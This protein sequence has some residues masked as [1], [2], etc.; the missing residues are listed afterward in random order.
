MKDFIH[1]NGFFQN[2]TTHWIRSFIVA[3]LFALLA[4]TLHAVGMLPGGGT[5]YSFP[6]PLDSWS[7]NDTTNWTS[8]LGYA[9]ASFTNITALQFGNVTSL[10][11]NTNI[12]AW[13]Q[14]NVAENDGTT[15]LTVDQGSVAFWFAPAWAG[16]NEGGSGPGQWGRLIEV[17][18]YTSDASFGWWSLYE[19]DVGANLYFTVQ[20][21]DGSTTTY[22]TAPIAWTTNYWHFIALT[23][24]ATNTALY[25]DGVLATNGTGITAWPGTNVLAGGFYIGS[26]S[27]GVIQAQGAF[28]DFH[29]YNVPLDTNTVRHMFNSLFPDYY[30]NPMNYLNPMYMMAGIGSAPSNPSSSTNYYQAI[31]GPGSL[32]LVGSASSCVTSTKVWITNVVATAAGPGV[33]NV[34]FTIEGGS[35]GVP[36]DVFAN[37][38]LGFGTNNFSWA[39]MGQGYQCNTYMLANLPNTSCYLIL[40]TPQDLDGDG[41]TDAYELL[42]SHTSPTNSISNLDGI[43][44]GWEILLGL[45]PQTSNLTQPGTR[46]N[47]T[48]NLADWLNQVS[49]RRTGSIT[50]DAEGNVLSVSQ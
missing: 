31:S 8:D 24:S 45:N 47:Y 33:M 22:L 11:L 30:L 23:Y 5:N 7:F 9:P 38:G 32:L 17:G 37:S 14:Y 41:L 42:V 48:Y 19:D 35:N 39:W 29:T 2:L 20:P 50:N 1:R 26:D 49:G 13:L 18:A 43:P 46:A 16:T 34:T 4:P 25:L 3:G 15:N 36:Y 6:T 12:P 28:N 27:N 21:G 44:D 40:G 10:G